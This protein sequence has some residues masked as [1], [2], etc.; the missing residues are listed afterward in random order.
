MSGVLAVLSL[1]GMPIAETIVRSQLAAI[2]HR[3]DCDP[4]L[5]MNGQLALGHVNRPTTPEAERELLPIASADGRYR[6][7]WDGRL[8]NRAEL[9][10]AL[11]LDSPA[12]RELTDAG[13]VLAAYAR[14]GEDC[15]QRLLGEWALVIWDSLSSTLFCAKDPLGWRPLFWSCR[16]GMLTVGSEP[17]QLLAGESGAP[18]INLEYVLRFLAG[19]MQERNDSCYADVHELQG[20]QIL[21]AGRDGIKVRNYWLR[22]RLYDTGLRRPEEY[23]EAFAAVFRQATRAR[24]RSNRPAG[25]SLSGG[26]DS[27][28]VAASAVQEGGAG[29]TAL[30]AYAADTTYMDERRYA[31]SVVDHLGIKQIE[32]DISDCWSLSSRWLTA[33]DFDQPD[34]PVQSA[35]QVRLAA[36]AE[37]AGLGVLLGG[38]GG[39]EWLSGG[40]LGGDG[41]GI[42]DALVRGR[43]DVAWRLSQRGNGGCSAAVDLARSCYRQLLPHRL[44]RIADRT[45]G[46]DINDRFSPALPARRGWVSFERYAETLAWRPKR[47][48][49]I[50]SRLYQEF[51]GPVIAWRDRRA[52][53]RHGVEVRTPFNDL[54]VVELMASTPEWIKRFD[55]RPKA[56]LRQAEYSLLPRQIPDRDDR[57]EYTELLRTGVALRER[58]RVL[59]GINSVCALSGVLPE[60]VRAETL[61]WVETGHRWAQPNWNAIT[62]GLW[63]AG[64]DRHAADPLYIRDRRPDRMAVERMSQAECQ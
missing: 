13:Y 19:A 49:A 58:E 42:A 28:Y 9:S 37:Q 50:G 29:I 43:P 8:D 27:S 36:A 38:E 64:L 60:R 45:R 1:D 3:G 61:H 14:W 32:V 62:T 51:A 30:T 24:L 26:L 20:G 33:A 56:L 35:T 15:V 6:L 40:A 10:V 17:Q 4:Q 48:A 22:P 12:A 52:L 23:V 44:Q 34:H 59:L 5:W 41:S 2:A 7:T 21:T 63:L 57:G 46:K 39:D 55:G 16:A 18:E 11:G 31:R 25:V 54:R 53:S 47:G